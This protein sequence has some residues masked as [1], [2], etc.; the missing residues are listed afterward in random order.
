MEPVLIKTLNRT[1]MAPEE[2]GG[3]QVFTDDADRTSFIM[4]ADDWDMMGHPESIEV[5]VEVS[6]G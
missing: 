3:W 4:K 1:V 6:H 5:R 2:S